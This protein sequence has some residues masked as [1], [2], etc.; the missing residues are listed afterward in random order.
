MIADDRPR[1]D[2]QAHSSHSDGAL[3]PEHVV[4]R[5][6]ASGVE[7]LALTDHD[8]VA[9]V[10]EALE[11]AAAIGLELVPAVEIS[12]IY[13]RHEDL[14]ILGYGLDHRSEELLGAL[15]A[16]RIDRAARADRMADALVRAGFH[17]DESVLD[18]RREAGGSIGRPHLARVV[19][20]DERNATRLADEGIERPE[21]MLRA[22]LLPG[23]PAYRRRTIPVVAEAIEL[24]HQAGGVAVWAHPFW[25]IEDPHEV[26]A[27]LEQFTRFGLDGVESFYLSHDPMQATLLDEASLG[28][29]LLSTG[30]SDFHGPDHAIFSA[31]RAF[32]LH[33]LEPRLGPIGN[34]GGVP[35]KFFN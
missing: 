6:H 9:G 16:F 10:D 20:E 35:R 30:S 13:G 27:T 15:E 5:A 19:F 8:T 31:F 11:A 23:T 1:F 26:L 4:A 22:Y 29:D 24:I 33:R 14:H 3:E 12:A 21:H 34:S 7:L 32:S 2:L 28:L 25:D 17:L 18:R